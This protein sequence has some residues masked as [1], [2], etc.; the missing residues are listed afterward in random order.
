MKTLEES[1]TEIEHIINQ[2]DPVLLYQSHIGL[3]LQ[4]IVRRVRTEKHDEYI[5]E[6]NRT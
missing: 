1:L 2:I 6:L 5:K 3:E 4:N